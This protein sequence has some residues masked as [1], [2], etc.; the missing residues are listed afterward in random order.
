MW[1]LLTTIKWMLPH[2]NFFFSRMYRTCTGK[3]ILNIPHPP[4]LPVHLN[5]LGVEQ[6]Q[7]EHFFGLHLIKKT[8]SISKMKKQRALRHRALVFIAVS[9]TCAYGPISLRWNPPLNSSL[10]PSQ[11]QQT[12]GCSWMVKSVQDLIS[13][14][15]Q[16]APKEYRWART[17]H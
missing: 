3:D 11:M 1:P 9:E 5:P 13:N 14:T 6:K 7:Q 10:W 4:G 12:L 16:K 2:K 15:V 17:S 8:N